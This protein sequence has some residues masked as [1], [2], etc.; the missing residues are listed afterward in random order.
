MQGDR[1]AVTDSTTT[2]YR[3]DHVGFITED[4]DHSL[5]AYRALGVEVMERNYRRGTHDL[6][7][8]GAGTDVLLEFQAPPLLPESEDYITKHGWSIERIAL[9]CDDAHRAYAELTAAGIASAWEPEEFAV[10][11]VPLAI[12][13]GVWSPEGLMIDIVQHLNVHVPRPERRARGD[14]ALHHACCLVP[15]LAKAEDFWTTN[16]GLRKTYDFTSPL[17]DGGTKG[18]VM[19]GDPSFDEGSHEFTLEII[20]G[21]FDTIDG[22]VFERRGACFDHICFTT[23]DVDGT[24]QRAVEAGVEPLSAPTYYAEYN[25]TIAWLY[26]ADG[27]HIELMTPIPEG[28]M[29]DAFATG[30]CSNH[31]VDDWQRSAVV[32]PRS[33]GLPVKV[34]R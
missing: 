12:A 15:D 30:S 11:G 1:H 18:F 23:S 33:G 7:F 22:P 10:D 21:E 27:T 6:A 25:S 13:A 16:F 2:R 28:L 8:A 24:W 3:F 9:V 31:W 32:L 34:H 29:A 19:L 4:M 20:G 5:A 17:V 14:L 26:D